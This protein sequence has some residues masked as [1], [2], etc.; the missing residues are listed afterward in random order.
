MS[1]LHYSPLRAV[2]RAVDAGI[3]WVTAAGNDAKKTWF[4]SG[5]YLVLDSDGFVEFDPSDILNCFLLHPETKFNAELRWD[6]TWGGATL[7][8]DLYLW[9][10]SRRDYCLAQ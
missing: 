3:V 9:D 10:I 8:M 4:G 6:D 2:D 7:D 1:S 5:S